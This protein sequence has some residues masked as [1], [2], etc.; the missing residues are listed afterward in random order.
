MA[1][2][3]QL[4]GRGTIDVVARRVFISHSRRSAHLARGL[5]GYLESHGFAPWTAEAQLAPGERWQAAVADA[6]RSAD[7]V[8]IF[9]EPGDASDAVKYEWSVAL[10]AAWESEEKPLVALPLDDAE[11]PPFLRHR[12]VVRVASEQLTDDTLSEV[13]AALERGALA[14]QEEPAAGGEDDA[15]LAHRLDEAIAALSRDERDDEEITRTRVALGNELARI[16]HEFGVRDQRVLVIAQSL[17]LL[18][19]QQG[20]FE[21]ASA[22]Y[23]LAIES[24]ARSGDGDPERLLGLRMGCA[25]ALRR[26]GLLR[27]AE[28]L[29]ERALQD[30]EE[31]L[32]ADDMR[33]ASAAEALGQVR[34][35][36]GMSATARPLFERAVR[37]YEQTLGASHP[38]TASAAYSLGLV[39]QDLGEWEAARAALEKAVPLTSEGLAD[40]DDPAVPPRAIALGRALRELGDAEGA[41]RILRGTYDM[42]VAQ[43]DEDNPWLAAA[44]FG[45]GVA[46]RGTGDS[47]ASIHMLRRAL[48]L[49]ER[50]QNTVGIA[51]SE[52]ALGRGLRRMGSMDE[53]LRHLERARDLTSELFGNEDSRTAEVMYSLALAYRDH[54]DIPRAQELLHQAIDVAEAGGGKASVRGV[55]YRAAL[56]ELNAAPA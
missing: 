3:F 8:V 41:A 11:L 13:A 31:T 24:N 39:L 46:L 32:A 45:L 55:R 51:A 14:A 5:S 22:M 49:N 26:R 48:A 18:A 20:D 7:A 19:E 6:I 21:Q 2:G 29:L 56:A 36:R 40:T 33:V 42:L 52:A 30:S 9:V 50:T 35:E 23:E 34:K 38:R 15:Q 10:Q 25:R 44:A 43:G 53:A 54:G 4:G 28:L 47:E 17:A 16:R 12:R 37:V 27:D 1:D